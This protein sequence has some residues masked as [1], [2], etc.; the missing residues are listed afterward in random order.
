MQHVEF[1]HKDHFEKNYFRIL[2]VPSLADLIDFYWEIDFDHLWKEYPEGFSDVLFPNIGYTYLI[3]LGTPF[4]MQ[5][6]NRK[7]EMRTDGFLPRHTCLEC[8][9]RPGNKIFGIKFKISP[10]MFEKKI[11]FSEYKGHIFPLS[12]LVQ[13]KLVRQIKVAATFKERVKLASNYY[14]SIVSQYGGSKHPVRIVTEILEHCNATNNF[15]K[16][17]AAWARKYRLSTRTL[18]RYFETTTSVSTK[19]AL[20]ILRIRKATMHLANDPESFRYETYGY[21]DHSHFY[22]HLKQFLKK[23]TLKKIKPHLILLQNAKAC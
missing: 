12:Y 9:H 6:E 17:V 1:F 2:P 7:Y 21:Y 3:N 16:P 5:L 8:H 14:Q 18:Q 23:D 13:Q 4:V 15:D 11:N 10:V 22:K 19:K 20:Q